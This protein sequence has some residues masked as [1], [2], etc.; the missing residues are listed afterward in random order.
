MA[1]AELLR[2]PNGQLARIETVYND[3]FITK[4]SNELAMSFQ[5]KRWEYTESEI[6][7][8]DADDLPTLYTRAM[9]TAVAFSES[10]K[11]IL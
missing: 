7:L 10:P 1:R 9:T 2:R 6:N 8:R 3:I 4:H 11:R 5:L